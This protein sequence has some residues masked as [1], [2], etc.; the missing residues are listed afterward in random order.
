[1]APLLLGRLQVG[2]GRRVKVPKDFKVGMPQR[3]GSLTR[4]LGSDSPAPEMPGLAGQWLD[5]RG[6]PLPV[7]IAIRIDRAD[8]GR[9]MVTGLLIGLDQRREIT[10]ETL[11]QIKLA[12][13]LE[14][15]FAGFDVMNPARGV[16]DMLSMADPEW[17]RRVAALELWNAAANPW[18]FEDSEHEVETV[19]KPRASVATNLTEFA[20]VYLRHLAASPHKATKATADELHISRATAIRRIDECR[21][22]G[23]LP[24][25]RE[26][27]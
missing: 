9:F 7:P 8:D 25:R 12:T 22:A 17:D 26:A 2:Y 10:W 6:G 18:L 13:V 27:R 23:L 1:M 4:P 16:D 5:V 19:T 3:F 11:R 20:S 21:R 24:A 15:L 14:Y